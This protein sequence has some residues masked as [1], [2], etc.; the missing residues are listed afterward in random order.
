M[1]PPSLPPVQYNSKVLPIPGLSVS[2]ECNE[3]TGIN[4]STRKY[5]DKPA[6]KRIHENFSEQKRETTGCNRGS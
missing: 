2:R 5:P 3:Y 4:G 6:L 1:L